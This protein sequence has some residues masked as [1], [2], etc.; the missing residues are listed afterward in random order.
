MI[1]RRTADYRTYAR[2]CRQHVRSVHLRSGKLLRASR[3][4]IVEFLAADARALIEILTMI[5]VR[6]ADHRRAFPREN[7]HRTPVA[8]MHESERLRH[9]Q[10]PTWQ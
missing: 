10:T 4:Q 7:E 6:G 5:E 9:R 3:Q 8:L 2:P 1:A